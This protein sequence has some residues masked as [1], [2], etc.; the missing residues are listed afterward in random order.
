MTT[1]YDA[2]T[3]IL[4][5]EDFENNGYRFCQE[6]IWLNDLIA[7]PWRIALNHRSMISLVTLT[8]HHNLQNC[9]HC[10]FLAWYY[11]LSRTSAF[12]M[13]GAYPRCPKT[14]LLENARLAGALE[15]FL[16]GRWLLKN[17]AK[18]Q[19]GKDA[20]L[21]P[22]ILSADGSLYSSRCRDDKHL[23]PSFLCT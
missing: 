8:G 6:L 3:L 16:F 21:T 23:P 15:L 11:H 7:T 12:S 13:S 18:K 10:L 14:G 2:L 4:Y 5:L 20:W 19:I 9:V 1:P 22:R 17:S